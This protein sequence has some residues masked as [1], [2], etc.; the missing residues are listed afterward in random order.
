MSAHSANAAVPQPA[1]SSSLGRA[2]VALTT[3][4]A[5][6]VTDEALTGFL[7]VYNPTVLAIRENFPNFPMPVFTF[8]VWLGGLVMLV[9]VLF[10][11]SPFA[12]RNRRWIRFMAWPLAVIM[13]LN[14][15]GH[16]LGTIF[17]HTVPSVQFARPMPGFYSSPLLAAASLFM[18]WSLRKTAGAN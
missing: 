6:H 12:F 15:V 10:L 1:S 17:G 8:R 16:T 18:M 11:L 4:L 9:L 2:W 14:A 7:S 13:L 5:L 3:A